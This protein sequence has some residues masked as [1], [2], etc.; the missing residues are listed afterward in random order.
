MSLV[1]VD[2]GQ[3]QILCRAQNQVRTGALG[4][5]EG[6][7]STVEPHVQRPWGRE[8]HKPGGWCDSGGVGEG[9][10]SRR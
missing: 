5:M 1:I 7:L 9:R 4:P 2:R 3:G 10:L 8:E 6:D